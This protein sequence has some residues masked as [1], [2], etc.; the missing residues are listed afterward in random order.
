MFMGKDN[1]YLF[2][3]IYFLLFSG[4]TEFCSFVYLWQQYFGYLLSDVI[5]VRTA[6]IG[7]LLF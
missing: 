4:V 5:L 3:I 1:K 7:I 6:H 2:K